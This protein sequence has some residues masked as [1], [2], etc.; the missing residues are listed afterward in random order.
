MEKTET[1]ELSTLSF[2]GL[3]AICMHATKLQEELM[4]KVD[5]DVCP[6]FAKSQSRHIVVRATAYKNDEEQS[7]ACVVYEHES[8]ADKFDEYID[9]VLA[10]R[11]FA[12][13]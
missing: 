13:G 2:G 8:L 3:V 12:E 1:F 9:F 11:E 6:C 10:A 5:I 7:R 4:G